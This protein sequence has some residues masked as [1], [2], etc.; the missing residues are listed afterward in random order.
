M[1]NIDFTDYDRITDV[2]MYLSDKITL[3]FV[4]SLSKK[5]LNKERQFFHYETK[6][7]SDSYNG[8]E[9]RSIKRNMNF[10]FVL[11]NREIFGNGIVLR[12]QDV[13]L[14]IRIIDQ[15]VLCWFFGTVKEHAFRYIDGKLVLGEFSPVVYTQSETKYISFE[16]IVYC[17]EET[18]QYAEGI[19]MIFPNGDSTPMNLDKFM[20]FFHLLKSDMYSVACSLANYAKMQPY[21]INVYSPTGLGASPKPKDNWNS[22]P[23][24]YNGFGSN[25]FLDK[26]ITKKKD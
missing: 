3:N 1:S 9:L 20:G 4:L 18:G 17:Y 10:Y 8:T 25:A 26:S 5:T 7:N 24:N 23:I 19:T 13:E 11:G 2:L 14:L 6:Y 12:P 21:G 15:K 16:P 22:K